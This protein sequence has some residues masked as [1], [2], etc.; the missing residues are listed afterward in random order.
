MKLSNH[1]PKPVWSI[2]FW[3]FVI[4]FFFHCCLP[5]K[6]LHYPHLLRDVWPT[7]LFA[8]HYCFYSAHTF[9][10]THLPD[11]VWYSF[12]F[13]ALWWKR[14]QAQIKPKGWAF[15]GVTKFFPA[16]CESEGKEPNCTAV[17]NLADKLQHDAAS[18]TDLALNSEIW[19]TVSMALKAVL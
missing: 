1:E 17:K 10:Y 2:L 7:E 19:I 8:T 12:S 11:V 3:W 6:L 5:K 15:S 18:L 9:N 16:V 4:T 13:L 14:S